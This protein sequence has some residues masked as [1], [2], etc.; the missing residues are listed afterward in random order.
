[1][2]RT[3]GRRPRPGRDPSVVLE[4]DGWQAG[5]RFSAAH[6]IP[7][8]EKCSR[9]HG[10]TYGVR[11]RVTGSPRGSVPVVD[12]ARLRTEVRRVLAPLHHRIIL[13]RRSAALK[14]RRSG[15]T[16]RFTLEGR[17]YEVPST[18]VALLDIRDSTAEEIARHLVR[19]LS[20][21][22]R[23]GAVQRLE[24]GVD[25]GIGQGAWASLGA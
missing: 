17:V 19:R 24:L 16:T 13:P 10:H 14:V 20:L 5:L 1:M 7:R 11:V 21:R 23:G 6:I 9:L 3:T 15:A 12:L 22:L 4:L 25:E 18:S 2:V 8:H